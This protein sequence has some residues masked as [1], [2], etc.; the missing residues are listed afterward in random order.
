VGAQI[1]PEFGF[2][3]G[4]IVAEFSRTVHDFRRGAFSF[5]YG[6]LLPAPSR[7]PAP[8]GSPIYPH[9]GPPYPPFIPPFLP[10][11]VPQA[12]VNFEMGGQRG[13]GMG[14]VREGVGMKGGQMG[15]ERLFMEREAG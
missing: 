5:L 15:E 12:Q 6:V 10:A 4:V 3:G 14:E 2:S 7:L 8:L 9:P 11:P 1:R 13:V